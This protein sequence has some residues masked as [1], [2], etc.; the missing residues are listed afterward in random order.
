MNFK[1]RILK[2]SHGDAILISGNF[3]GSPR[4]ILIDGGPA[5]AYQHNVF[6]GA[7]KKALQEL[8]N[9]NQRVDLLILTHVDD[10]HI[11]GLLSGFD[12]NGLL[13]QLTDKVWFNSGKLIFE[14]FNRT[15]DASNSIY[16]NGNNNLVG[17]ERSTSI[18]QG[19]E[20]ES[21]ISEKGIWYQ[22][23]ILAGQELT[24]FGIKF[25]ILSPTEN[26]LK[27]LLMVWKRKSPESLTSSGEGD[28]K[29]KF[30]TLLI[31]DKFKE[32]TSISNGSSI[33]FIFEYNEKR[34]LM[35]GDAHNRVIIES[36]KK[37]KYSSENPIKIDYVKLAHHG[38][39]KNTSEELL[40]MIDC[41]DFIF[42][43]NTDIHRLPNKTTIARLVKVKPQSKLWFN[44][45]EII[46]GTIFKN[47]EE[48]LKKLRESGVVLTGC[49]GSIEV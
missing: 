27:K 17:E 30:D 46:E 6:P 7:L 25:T 40:N 39:K 10:D 35:L 32:D 14:H 21:L 19:V 44:Y 47:D 3:D 22:Q 15:P 38:S 49:E 8:Q 5:K 11:D 29:E 16:L 45:P 36:L 18:A 20:F 23:L 48:N 4:N 34:I 41:N 43:S 9:N 12:N 13:A 24:E 28:Y 1:L 42:S 26:K 33:A 31:G 37:L 2:A